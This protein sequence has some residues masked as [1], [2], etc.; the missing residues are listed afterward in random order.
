HKVILQL[1]LILYC[2]TNSNMTQFQMINHKNLMDIIQ[3]LKTSSCC[4]DILPTG[5]FKNV[6]NCLPSDLLKTTMCV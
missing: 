6:S 3:H 4:L 2:K 5:F 1:I